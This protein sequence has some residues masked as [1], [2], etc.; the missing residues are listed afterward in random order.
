MKHL[1]ILLTGASGFIGRQALRRCVA[2]GHEVYA[3]SREAPSEPDG[4][5]WISAN[6]LDPADRRRIIEVAQPT[7][8]LH[9]AWTTTHGA[10]W[11]AL[12][13]IDWLSATLDLARIFAEFGGRRLVAAGTCWEYEVNASGNALPPK[14][15]Q[16]Y[17][18]TKYACLV[19]LRQLAHKLGFG[20]AWGRVF[21]VY[22]EYEKPARLVPSV[23]KSLLAGEEARCT[24]GTQVRDF[25]HVRDLGN[26]FT[27]LLL[28]KCE[29]SF[30][31]GSGEAVRI[32]DLVGLL[33]AL[34]DRGH[35]VRLGAL[36]D[37]PGE[38]PELVA[39]V[40]RLHD[41]LSF[42]PQYDL[43]NGLRETIAWWKYR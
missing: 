4:A 21:F 30:D 15:H 40:S 33:G 8:L 35:L 20:L 39:N 12:E 26:A 6:L 7:H 31:L 36:P 41:E 10:F 19:V 32:A 28:S 34:M 29:G 16:L 1:R 23:I 27:K 9:L 11:S 3:V 24:S 37:R 43:Q 14:E 42:V 2:E 38:C 25:M 17:A 5:F 13:N 18:A 22:G